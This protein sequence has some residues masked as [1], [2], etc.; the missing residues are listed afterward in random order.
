MLKAALLR[1]IHPML[2]AMLVVTAATSIF[3]QQV[4]VAQAAGQV[5][6]NT[7]AVVPG[8]TRKMMETKRGVVHTAVTDTKGRYV[9]PGHAAG[10]HRL[11]IKK[12]MFRAC[13]EEGSVRQCTD[14]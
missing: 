5:T 12:E 4:N 1:M 7:G 10:P 11:E 14:H 6:D 9:V 8:A 2:C 13:A 3:A